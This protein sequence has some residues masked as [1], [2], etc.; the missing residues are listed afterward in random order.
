MTTKKVSAKLIKVSSV[1]HKELKILAAQ[2]E[3]SMSDCIDMLF[4]AYEKSKK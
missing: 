3:C 4:I 1:R 2:L